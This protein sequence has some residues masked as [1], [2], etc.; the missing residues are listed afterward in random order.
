MDN[1][2]VMATIKVKTKN[3]KFDILHQ[4]CD[5]ETKHY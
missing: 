3:V 2:T 4:R 1:L 5:K